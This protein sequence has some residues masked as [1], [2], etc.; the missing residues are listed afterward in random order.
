MRESR[1]LAIGVPTAGLLCIGALAANAGSIP[2]SAVTQ[3]ATSRVIDRTFV[4]TPIAYSGVGDLDVRASPTRT[5]PRTIPRTVPAYLVVRTGTAGDDDLVVVRARVHA[6]I[7]VV[8]RAAGPAGVYA[9]A[10]RCKP[11]RVSP[12]LTSKPFSGPPAGWY[13]QVTCPL[14]GRVL[15]RVR[16]QLVGSAGW[17]RVDG[18]FFGAKS[19]VLVASLAVRSQR[20][21][22]PLAF[23]RVDEAGRTRLWT[24]SR[25]S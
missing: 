22:E 24:S 16:A 15:V 23:M 20:T 17:R 13:S 25:C 8:T 4:C 3:A 6:A 14:R 19:P 7:G 21:G 10:R 11:A 5:D 12:P 9:H 1:W 2:Q 18:S